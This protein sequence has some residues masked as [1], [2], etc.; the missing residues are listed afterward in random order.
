MKPD[1]ETTRKVTVLVEVPVT[2]FADASLTYGPAGWDVDELIVKL[3]FRVAK[4]AEAK[5][6][7]E[8][9]AERL[10]DQWDERRIEVS[11]H[12]LVDL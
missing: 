5:A 12:L 6:Q 1:N 9:E 11:R 3:G 8:W 2:Y 10:A 7:S 4:A